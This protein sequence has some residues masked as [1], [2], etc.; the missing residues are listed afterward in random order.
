MM[1]HA[2]FNALLRRQHNERTS[3]PRNV[4]LP[5]EAGIRVGGDLDRAT[6]LLSEVQPQDDQVSI[7]CG[8]HLCRKLGAISLERCP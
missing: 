3:A 4:R 8:R 6:L 5:S 7:P 2:K 1:T